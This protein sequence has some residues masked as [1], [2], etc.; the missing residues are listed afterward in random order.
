MCSLESAS[1]VIMEKLLNFIS[2]CNSMEKI[3]ERYERYS[4]AERQ[5]VAA[6]SEGQV[7]RPSTCC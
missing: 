7:C 1:L 5:L 4:Y 3:L 6:D 2:V